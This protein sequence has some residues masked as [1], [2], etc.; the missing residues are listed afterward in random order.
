A[1]AGAVGGRVA[2][3]L[4]LA[5]AG[6]VAHLG[7]PAARVA[8]APAGAGR[9]I[10]GEARLALRVARAERAGALLAGDRQ[11]ERGEEDSHGTVKVPSAKAYAGQLP[12]KRSR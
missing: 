5:E 1:A 8:R 7:S 12:E 10:A 4:R 11:H 6:R 2:A 3:Q 9:G